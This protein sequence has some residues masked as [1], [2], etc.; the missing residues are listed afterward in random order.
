[1]TRTAAPRPGG[2]VCPLAT[3]LTVD[4]RLDERV[5]R[6]LIDALV[7]ALDG[8]FVLGSSGELTWLPDDT[9]IDVARVAVDQ[10][11]GRIPVYVGVGDTG[12]TRT[13]ARADRL[14]KIGADYLVV[15]APFYYQVASA[16][17]VIDHFE[18]IAEQAPAPVVLYNIPQNTH[19]PL[20]P[21]TV[22]TLAGH[23]NIVGIKDSA[24]DWN[25]FE[26]FLALR[27]DDFSVMQGRER[28]AAI[29]LWS[30]ADGLISAMA[31]FAPRL[32][33]ALAASIRDDGPRAE[34]RVLQATIGELAAVFDQ[35][36]WLAGLK[37]TLQ[38]SGWNV[39]DPSPPIPPHDAAQRLVIEGILSR[40]EIARWLTMAPAP[41][42]PGT[43]AIG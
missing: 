1:M 30:G 5:L 26:S 29:S 28:L 23:P 42:R 21:A 27:A 34:T 33:Q 4:G 7:P 18:T 6:G 2:I 16:A 22:A 37:T 36:D 13:L 3:P 8:L 35:G 17:G 14:G 39:G 15:A 12:L 20:A 24:G 31:N 43:A 32:L 41:A 9:A 38:V 19:L 25:T 10:A 40:P 11:A